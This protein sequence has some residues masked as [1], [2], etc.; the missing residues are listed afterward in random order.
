ME[1]RENLLD[2]QPGVARSGSRDGRLRGKGF[3]TG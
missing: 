1:L 3:V 2:R